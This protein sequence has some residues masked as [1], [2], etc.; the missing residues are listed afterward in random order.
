[1]ALVG[2]FSNC[3]SCYYGKYAA[4]ADFGLT[5]TMANA[6]QS[7]RHHSGASYHLNVASGCTSAACDDYNADSIEKAIEQAQHVVIAAGL[8]SKFESEG[9]DRP[10]LSLPG[11]QPKLIEDAVAAARKV[12]VSR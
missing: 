8:G 12:G 4:R 9:K 1:M 2:P 5:I 11:D 6:L 3:T 7:H 10:N